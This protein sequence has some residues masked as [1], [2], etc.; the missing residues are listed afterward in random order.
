MKCSKCGTEASDSARF[1]PRC[2]NTLRFE[3]PACHHEQRQGG[4]CEKC[5]VD[6]MKYFSAVLT[7]KKAESDATHS[8]INERSS[9]LK[10]IVLLPF[11]MGL[12]FLRDLLRGSRGG[13]R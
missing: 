6:F 8:K 4:K 12:P 5:G 9:L 3:C 2:H 1:C 11:N 13:E 7:M 10:N